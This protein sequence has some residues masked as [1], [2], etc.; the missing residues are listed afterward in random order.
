MVYFSHIDYN[1]Q[2]S[3][4]ILPPWND[5]LVYHSIPFVYLSKPAV[6]RSKEKAL[7]IRL[8]TQY[9]PDM[10][11]EEYMKAYNT[12]ENLIYL[13]K[14]GIIKIIVSK[15]LIQQHSKHIYLN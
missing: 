10:T 5:K 12:T 4:N 13:L 14:D 3:K 7:D 15:I 1:V 9:I 11:Q 2:T 8:P 6:L